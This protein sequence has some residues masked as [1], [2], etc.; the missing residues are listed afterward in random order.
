[1]SPNSWRRRTPP[2]SRGHPLRIGRHAL[3]VR[4]RRRPGDPDP[5]SP[6]RGVAD[7]DGAA[8]H[9][10]QASDD[11]EAEPGAAALAALPELREDPGPHLGGD[12][13]ALVVDGDPD[14]GLVAEVTGA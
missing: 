6:A 1:M 13:L 7:H 4:D 9:L 14:A 5:R 10:G 3:E 11:V 12:A 8:V 2:R